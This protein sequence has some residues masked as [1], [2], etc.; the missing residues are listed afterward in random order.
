DRRVVL[1]HGAEVSGTELRVESLAVFMEGVQ[2]IVGE[3]VRDRDLEGARAKILR[4]YAD[5]LRLRVS[6]DLAGGE[7]DLQDN[8]YLQHERAAALKDF[9]LHRDVDGGAV[10]A[11]GKR[12]PQAEYQAV[13]QTA[14]TVEHDNRLS[15]QSA[16]F[17]D[18]HRCQRVRHQ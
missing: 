9:D 15:T 4:R 2:L 7:V 16:L 17:G 13:S 3:Q 18:L 12:R 11:G 1:D 6:G 14:L 10:G 5:L 8:R